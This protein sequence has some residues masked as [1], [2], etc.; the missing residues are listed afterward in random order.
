MNESTLAAGAAP[1]QKNLL[2]RLIGVIFSPEETFRDVAARPRW[3][4]MLA[5]T[6]ILMAVLVGGFL[7]TQVGQDA[8]LDT[9]ISRS[10]QMSDQQIAA[11]ERVAGFVGYI[12]VAYVM[13]FVPIMYVVVAGILFAIFNVGFGGEARFKQVFAVVV[14]TAPI[15]VLGQ[16]FTIPINYA[17][18][19]MASATTL[20]AL[21]PMIDDE[22]FL[23]RFLGMIDLFLVWQVIVLAIGLA[24]LYRRRS[25]GI[26]ASL[27]VVYGVI[28]LVA[29]G[30]M[31]WLS[32]S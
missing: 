11:M 16:L 13:I 18:G 1:A 12:T 5:F 22:S 20:G 32:G 30:I 21:L 7:S 29:A 23:G 9:V 15:G 6:C 4:G 27:L 26:A 28:A 24:V 19:A 2:G 3:L 25:Q 31:G 17:R 8:W 10:G 14:H